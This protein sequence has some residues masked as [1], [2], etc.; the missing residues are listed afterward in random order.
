MSLSLAALFAAAPLA[1]QTFPTDDPVIKRIWA[2][3][4]DS[5]Q[6]EHLSHVLFDSI[7]P[8]LTGTPDMK[9]AN[10]W[11]V[12][13]Y[14]SWG[15]EARNEQFGTWRG[16]RRG[17]SHI[18][19]VAPRVRSLEGTMLGYSPGT[20]R[21][22]LT[23]RDD[24]P[25]PLR[26]QHRVRPLAAHRPGQAGAGRGPPAHLPAPGRL[27]PERDPGI[28]GPDGQPAGLGAARVGRP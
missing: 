28:E 23:R 6:T 12:A 1:A 5:S 26:R 2:I 27:G 15:I 11:L 10:D 8:R 14:R 19:L 7:G 22:D 24:H 21:R 18:D 3:G 4:M 16:W 13:T 9:R 20:N 25:A 17:Y